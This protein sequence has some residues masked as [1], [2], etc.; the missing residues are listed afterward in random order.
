MPS[1]LGYLVVASAAPAAWEDFGT[2]LLGM[3]ANRGVDGSVCLRMDDRPARIIIEQADCDG[4]LAYGWEAANAS[5][6]DD[7]SRRL[8][9]A[10]F[11]VSPGDDDL[12][13]RRGV[14]ALIVTR[15]L[16]GN[17]IEIFH[18]AD[19]AGEPFRPGRPISG[20]R[21]GDLGLGHATLTTDDVARAEPFYTDLM[22]MRL[23]DYSAEPFAARFYHLNSRHHSLA[24]IDTGAVGLH[25][26]MMEV[27]SLDDVGQAY[28]LAQL[29]GNCI[30]V[31]LGR[32]SND[33][34]T[35]FYMHSPSGFMVEY[36][37]GG[38]SIDPAEWQPVECR[39][40]PSLWGHEREWLGPEKRA[41]A[42]EMRLEAAAS[43]LR[44]PDYVR[45]D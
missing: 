8:S 26:L 45:P 30:A 21:T 11:A 36:G 7:H 17:R 25:H 23:S 19:L 33:F 35:S 29:D 22:G 5:D 32:H 27:N 24:L 6:M 9:E 14:E 38:R 20:F 28:D 16:D 2:R 12:A 42:L 34:I 1:S 31:T 41:Q 3:Q 15:D 13:R 10:G 37:W 4:P 44:A 43:G 18:N 39:N 40:G